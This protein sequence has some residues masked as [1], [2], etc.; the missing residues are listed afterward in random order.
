MEVLVAQGYHVVDIGITP[1]PTVQ[2]MVEK[3]EADGGIAITASHNPIQWNG[4]KFI[5][6]DG[7]FLPENEIMQMFAISDKNDFQ[8]SQYNS[9]G[10]EEIYSEAINNHLGL[11]YNLSY[12]KTDLIKKK[13]F[14]VV[15]DSVNGAGG[16]IM[17]QLLKN[18]GCEVFEL[19]TETTGL[20]AH[21]PEPLPENLKELSE[22]VKKKNAD[23]GIAVDP[24]VDRCAL[25]GNDGIPLGEEYTLALTTKLI[26]SKK[27]GPVA[28]NMSTS[29]ATEDVVTYYNS[30][31]HRTKVGEIHV[32][33]KMREIDAVIGGEGNGGV[34]LPEVHLGRDAPVAAALILQLMAES[35]LTINQ[36]KANIN[37]YFM[38]KEKE[39]LADIDGDKVLTHFAE[40]YK[41]GQ[42]NN[43]DGIKI[44]FDNS[45]VHLRKSNTEP[46][47]RI[48]AEASNEEKVKELIDM[49]KK[50]IASL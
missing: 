44:D 21:T 17:T 45:W 5:G 36:L 20:F 39:Q 47:I 19:N 46:I 43:L 35:G 37:E 26:L 7:L 11:I 23:L 15:I 38:I 31:L 6:P 29:K 1:T 49:F 10:K 2:I 50:E 41:D 16:P 3:L 25:V 9:L 48:I 8:Y 14:K 33:Q 13:K 28:I 40:K 30:I 27:M 22:T 18:L 32:A 12:I 42:V 4:L 34:I 24:D